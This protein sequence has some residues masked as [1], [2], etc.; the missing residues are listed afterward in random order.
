MNSRWKSGL[1]VWTEDNGL[2]WNFVCLL[3][4][5]VTSE[6]FPFVLLVSSEAFSRQVWECLPG[7]Y[8]IGFLPYQIESCSLEPWLPFHLSI[9]YSMR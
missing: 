9:T 5:L 7:G 1:Y 2:Q 6:A 4:L 3:L 8:S